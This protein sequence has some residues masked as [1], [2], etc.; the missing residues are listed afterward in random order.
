M[1]RSLK[2][3]EGYTVSAMDGELGSVADLFLDDRR[4]VIRYL[5]V[6]TGGFLDRRD[7]LVSPIAFRDVDWATHLFHV[8]L[9]RDKLSRSPLVDTHM[10]VSR[11]HELDYFRYF[12]YSNYWVGT[13]LWG[14]GA[15]P[16]PMAAG[17]WEEMAD[18][19]AN[20]PKADHHLRSASA[21][22]GYRLEGTDES[23]GHVDDFIVDDETW[24]IRYLVIAT[25]MAWFGKKVLVSPFWATRVSWEENTIHVGVTRQQVLDCPAWDP[26]AGVNRSYEERMYDFYGR[27]VYWDSAANHV[28]IP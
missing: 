24:E 2:D 14:M 28:E 15:L 27:P 19:A 12:G 16:G 11:Q 25:G 21:V 1:L 3:L 5:V 13:G 23:I 9:T 26:E 22:R 18:H 20:G 17:K 7:V 4:W 8:A 6:N 10:P